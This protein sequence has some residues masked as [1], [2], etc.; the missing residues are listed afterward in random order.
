MGTQGYKG[1]LT[2]AA[3]SQQSLQSALLPS[4]ALSDWLAIVPRCL[5][6][7]EELRSICRYKRMCNFFFF[8][9]EAIVYI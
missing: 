7:L 1:G 3:W 8:P 4:S 6:L 5:C 9:L 2:V